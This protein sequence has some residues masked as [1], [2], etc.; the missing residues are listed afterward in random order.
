MPTY[1]DNWFRNTQLAT[2]QTHHNRDCICKAE[3]PMP[4]PTCTAI[5][6]WTDG[7]IAFSFTAEVSPYYDGMSG[8]ARD[9]N[10]P[11]LGQL[12][13]PLLDVGEATLVALLGPGD[14]VWL[15]VDQ[16]TAPVPVEAGSYTATITT[17]D[18]GV[19][20]TVPVRH[21][22]D[23]NALVDAEPYVIPEGPFVEGQVYCVTITADTVDTCAA[24]PDWSEGFV[25]FSITAGEGPG[26]WGGTLV[27]YTT[28]EDPDAPPGIGELHDPPSEGI[29]G[30]VVQVDV[31]GTYI[32]SV[33]ILDPPTMSDAVVTVTTPD[34][35]AVGTAPLVYE[36]GGMWTVEDHLAGTPL[37]PGTTYCVT[38]TLNEPTPP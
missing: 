18:G 3:R 25:S 22:A 23:N 11:P 29:V 16:L 7:S 27:G 26:P 1:D 35:T 19:Y 32:W 28:D 24:Q 30:A 38:I 9:P 34:G 6:E 36:Y 20:A 4:P 5:T 12:E 2:G 31:E 21:D 14:R 10:E 37:V 8:L 17:P 13:P 33:S 15:T